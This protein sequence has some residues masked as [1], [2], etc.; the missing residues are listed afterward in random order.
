MREL[1]NL[2]LMLH[3]DLIEL[4]STE[5]QLKSSSTEAELI[6]MFTLQ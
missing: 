2:T 1:H 4:L 3:K 6:K 5:E